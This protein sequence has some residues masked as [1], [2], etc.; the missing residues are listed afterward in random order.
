MVRKIVSLFIV[1]FLLFSPP[2]S[3]SGS[4]WQEEGY[5]LEA[6]LQVEAMDVDGDGRDE[7]I[8]LGRNYEAREVFIYTLTWSGSEWLVL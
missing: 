3:V 8:V 1:V 7:L 4:L 2:P 6:I 5:L